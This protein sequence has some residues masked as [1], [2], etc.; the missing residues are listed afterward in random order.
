MSDADLMQ[1]PVWYKKWWSQ[2]KLLL[3]KNWRISI[4]NQ[5]G[6]I[7]QMCAPAAFI[8]I[9]FILQNSIQGNTQRYDFFDKVHHQDIKS[10]E[11]IPHC[12]VGPDNDQCWT[13][14]YS[15][16]NSAIAD[17][18]MRLVAQN[19]HPPIPQSSIRAFATPQDIDTFLYE[20]LNTTQS[21]VLWDIQ[22]DGLGRVTDISYVLQI[23][24]TSQYSHGIEIKIGPSIFTPTQYAI[25]KAIVEYLAAN[26]TIQVE[27]EAKIVNFAHPEILTV[28]IIGEQG[29]IWFFA[30]LMF[31]F[32]VG[33]GAIVQEKEQKLRAIMQIMGLYDSVYW[34]TWF[35][36]LTAYST[37]T[38]MILI[39]F[40]C[41]FQFHFFLKN[42][43][44]LYFFLMELFALSLVSMTF[45]I[46][47]I[48]K[49]ASNSTG[50]GF[51]IFILGFFIQIASAIVYSDSASP[52]VRN[53]FS[54]FSPAVF[55]VGLQNLGLATEKES[56]QGLRWS[57]V[58]DQEAIP[59]GVISFAEIYGWLILDFFLYLIIAL[60]LDNV[61]PNAY[62]VSRRWY[63]FLTP[64]YWTGKSR[65]S[66]SS[67]VKSSELTETELKD[68]DE[69]VKAER[70][71]VV[72]NDL[73][74]HTA[75]VVNRLTKIYEAPNKC[76]GCT[77]GDPYLA[78]NELCLNIQ[79]DTLLCLLG[80]N[81]AGKTTTIHMLVGFHG[82]TAG[83]ATIFGHSVTENVQ[84]VQKMIGLCP[85][86]DILWNE[87]TGVEHLYLFAGLRNIPK[88]KIEAEATRLLEEVELTE[89]A[90][91][92]STM[93]S[94]GMRRRLSVAISLI[95]NP[96]IVFL[97]EPTTGMDPVSRR[98]VWNTIER[99]KKDKVIVLTTHSM[100]E[101]DVL[102]D[103]IAI[104]AKGRLQCVG[105]SLRLK[106]RFGAGYRVAV[107]THDPLVN[108]V[109]KYFESNITGAKVQGKPVGGYVNFT[110]P[111]TSNKELVPFFDGLEQHKQELGIHDLQ[112]SLTTLEE[113]F[114]TVAEH[115]ELKKLTQFMVD[116]EETSPD[117]PKKKRKFS[118]FKKHH[119]DEDLEA[120]SDNHVRRRDQFKALFI[121]SWILQKREVK[122]NICQILTPIILIIA[123][124]LLN[125]LVNNII[126]PTPIPKILNPETTLPFHFLSQPSITDNWWTV[127]EEV[128]ANGSILPYTYKD[129]SLGD[130]AAGTGFLGLL[131]P[132]ATEQFPH[133]FDEFSEFGRTL[134]DSLEESSHNMSIHYQYFSS[135]DA[136]DDFVYDSHDSGF[137]QVVGGYVF[138][139]NFNPS[140][141]QFIYAVM[142]NF[143][144][145][146]ARD[147]PFF[148]NRMTNAV[149][150][151]LPFP[152]S[153]IMTGL[154]T[155]PSESKSADIDLVT[156][157][158]SFFYILIL[159][160]LF[161]V[162]MANIVYE[163]ESKIK[164]MMD[165]MGLK[166]DIY[167]IVTY[168]FDLILYVLVILFLIL[169][170]YVFQFRLFT[171]NAF[172]SYFLLFI[173]W[174]N[175][176]IAQSFLFSV[177][178]SSKKT[179]LI[180]GY[181]YILG[182][183]LI[184]GVLV[185]NYV[186][187]IGG[188]SSSTLFGISI[189]PPFALYRGLVYLA[190][191]VAWE[192]PGYTM[193]SITNSAVN[194]GAVYGFLIVE[195][196][197]MMLF[198]VY[199]QQVVPSGWGVKKHPLF[200]LGFG[201]R[202]L[203]DT[204]DFKIDPEK[205]DVI[206]ERDRVHQHEDPNAVRVLDLRKVYP[207]LDGNPPK[208]AVQGVSFGVDQNSCL[209][210]LGHNG[211]GKTTTINMLIG[212]IEPTAGNAIVRGK[213]LVDDLNSIYTFIGICPQHDILWDNLT[214]KEHLEFYG[215]I[216]NLKGKEL[217]RQIKSILQ[218]VNLYDARN[219]YSTK[220]SGGMKR[221][222]SVAISLIGNPKVIYLDEPST[223]L[224]PKSRQDLWG[225]INEAKQTASVLLTT[226]SMEEADAICDRLMIM[227]DGEIQ[228]IGVSADLKKRF[229]EGYKLSVQVA[230]GMSDQPAH[231]F[232]KKL[233][234]EAILLNELAGTRN[235]EVSKEHVTLEAVFKAMEEN[236]DK[237]N[238]TDWAITNTTLEEVF[239]K[240]S[241]EEEA[242]KKKRITTTI[243]ME[244][245][246]PLSK[247]LI[248]AAL[249]QSN[250][251]NCK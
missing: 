1:N 50:I 119:E 62:G 192:G 243:T 32:V 35:I 89:A 20:N 217:K 122:T 95:G 137:P 100:E 182:V 30:A 248:Q 160:Q 213:S 72:K 69:D 183:A 251:S 70:D 61:M 210:V 17:E 221:R 115:A 77:T 198:W 164:D 187:D 85:Q 168:I 44:G 87:L 7:T 216:K 169:A 73:P 199:L 230:R 238:I 135:K 46:S 195:W 149:G 131:N 167:W 5:R 197:V 88:D 123:L 203:N 134:N 2:C 174:G 55:T 52:T 57:S 138:D 190:A 227:A 92:R 249:I 165:M 207:A 93:Y 170:G 82:A 233:I 96:R 161:P 18:I 231:E 157:A 65:P 175:V 151:T 163:K 226:H 3:W 76:C 58:N 237:L 129:G 14:V 109:I 121:K 27:Y 130:Y 98:K 236:K 235:Y 142:Y 200:F 206:A 39:V 48:V 150:K 228:C 186:S 244:L 21:A 74:A 54:L 15:P 45:L 75:V 25:D 9:L 108:D 162:F 191:E 40:G 145:T 234:P 245:P 172:G 124:Y 110:I 127:R 68:M 113:V 239:L 143:S 139:D 220:Y 222:L 223:G 79:S 201:K 117:V 22:F 144:L 153:I 242:Q 114:L 136:V 8:I 38:V 118:L 177:I 24:Q 47:T 132:P 31:N 13:M 224:D 51:L 112:L 80:P 26:Q 84:E 141:Y 12:V 188:V 105:S 97:D 99:A 194:L 103:K 185:D 189:V 209:G 64:S 59:G 23:N 83:D 104:M 53:L 247:W 63:Y 180:V 78:V 37:A 146:F 215:R 154:K 218:K 101:A 176:L 81:G 28:N 66:E 181:F 250:M 116:Q 205:H 232:I 179:A 159:H 229:G 71:S 152:I 11:N 156:L 246:R 208:V 133:K 107:G 178:F 212:L 241:M 94:G 196:I 111:R 126:D 193:S 184:C 60:Y 6:T 56:Y 19:N 16:N 10:I 240:I 90:H 147:I 120:Q 155:F 158:G 214:G 43:F 4:R 91:V 140:T 225:V 42:A 211:A 102:G 171:I 106:Q 148:V 41:I 49:K 202:S 204:S 36:T 33:V 166:T 125:L 67:A 128:I 29:P 86:F 173:I 34:L 219:K